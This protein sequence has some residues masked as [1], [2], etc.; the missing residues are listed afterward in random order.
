[1]FQNEKK[2][3]KTKTHQCDVEFFILLYCMEGNNCSVVELGVL[4]CCL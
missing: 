1:M 4:V 2:E 3:R